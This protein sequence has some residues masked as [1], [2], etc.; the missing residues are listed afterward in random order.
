M[1]PATALRP[2]RAA[3]VLPDADVLLD[4]AHWLAPPVVPSVVLH[5]G[6]GLPIDNPFA[7]IGVKQCLQ[8]LNGPY[9]HYPP[10][11]CPKFLK[12]H[13]T[14]SLQISLP[15]YLHLSYPSYIPLRPRYCIKSPKP[16]PTSPHV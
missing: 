13:P 1:N 16:G 6:G 11:S 2:V 15:S 7:E 3:P 12:S 4:G 14:A 10:Q 9:G 8:S 5:W